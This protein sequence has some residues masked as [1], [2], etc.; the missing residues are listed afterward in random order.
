MTAPETDPPR[1]PSAA[2]FITLAIL[3]VFGP[4]SA[5]AAK[6]ITPLILALVATLIQWVTTGSFDTAELVTAVTGTVAALI[7]YIVPNLP[8]GGQRLE[9]EVPV[10]LAGVPP[11]PLDEDDPHEPSDVPFV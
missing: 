4:K 6:A 10:A 9:Q 1:K 11:D 7:T 5:Q 2:E 3:R 8:L